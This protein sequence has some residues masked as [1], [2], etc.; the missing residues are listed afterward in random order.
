MVKPVIHVAVFDK[1]TV[2]LIV[3]TIIQRRTDELILVCP[4]SKSDAYQGILEQYPGLDFQT[5]LVDI[6]SYSFNEIL[7][8]LLSVVD[9]ARLDNYDI[10]FNVVCTNP[11]I[12]IAVCVAATMTQSL[13]ITSDETNLST[14]LL[15]RPNR[16]LHMS[17][18]KR[19]ILEYLDLQHSPVP[20]MNISRDT[21]ITRSCV[22]RHLKDLIQAAYVKRTRTG[23]QKTVE[24]SSLGKVVVR[25]KL[26]RK[27]VWENYT[28]S[29]I[30]FEPTGQISG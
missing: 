2:H 3:R 10:E 16:L 1:D 6:E 30:Y 22:S 27:R 19:K 20:Q 24:I 12:S 26:I 21:S 9:N 13:L 23:R 7:S 17:Q 18:N 4:V 14:P 29:K 5:T 15:L 25:H 11:I 8:T 28:P